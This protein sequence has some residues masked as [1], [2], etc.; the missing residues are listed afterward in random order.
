MGDTERGRGRE[1]MCAHD[2]ILILDYGS[3]F[4]QLIARRVREECVYCE[5]HPGNRPLDWI[6]EWGARGIILSGGPASVYD[7]DVPGADPGLLALGV[8]ILGICY[9]MH[10]ITHLEGALVVPGKREYGRAELTVE[11]PGA[12]FDGFAPGERTIVWCSHGDHVDA[13]PAGYR[14]LASTET[15]P[16]AALADPGRRL[17]GVQFHP[18]VAHTARGDEVISNFLFGVCCCEPTW[19][20]GTFIDDTV[21]GVLRQVGQGG[22]VIC[23]LS[24]GVD[25]SVAASLVHRAVGDRL[26]CVFVDNGLLR[27][28]ERDTV[29]RTFRKHM[30]M[31]LVVVDA[32]DRFLAA[33]AGV[34]E[35][36][37]KRRRIG[38]TFIEVFAD[39]VRQEGS[40]ARFLVQG[41]LY[42][43]VIESVSPRG[44]PS[45]TIKTHHNV[46]G[47]PVD[48]PFE[49][50][51]PVRELFKDEVRQVGRELGLPEEFV[52]RHPFP[53]PGLA[54]RVLGEVT[55][56]R[57]DVLREVDMIY[58]EEIRAG[59]LY[60]E[61]WQAFAVLLPVQSVGVMGD[62]RTYENVVAL[63][64]V[65]S[66]DGMTADWYPF[67]A[68]VLG[69]MSTRI[70]NEVRG[71]NRVTYDISSKPPATIEWE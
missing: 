44:G 21:D 42:P 30:H 7:A 68:E 65:T 45:A 14:V 9:G 36:E 58:L 66:R 17:Y 48:M 59:G 38:S 18:E 71:V 47:L 37:Q 40:D 32:A 22:R 67:P 6:R 50:I 60:D 11:N 8:P 19:T 64:A 5:I 33:L 20:A 35:P 13:P 24:G 52:G 70:I 23:G 15:L 34:T 41:T 46:G 39:V 12:L 29:E 28:H 27:K 26:T 51:E 56:P 10:L 3:Q 4:T 1:L 2:R 69:R 62:F 53:G 43:D 25:S 31:K 61:I 55:R 49:L 16:V 54:I 57:L 63:R